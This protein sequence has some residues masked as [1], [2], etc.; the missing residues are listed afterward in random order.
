MMTGMAN[1]V[2]SRASTAALAGPNTEEAI[3]AACD[4]NSCAIAEEIGGQVAN[5]LK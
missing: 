3:A 4:A 2:K 1:H 5:P